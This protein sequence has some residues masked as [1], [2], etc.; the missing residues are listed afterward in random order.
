MAVARNL[1]VHRHHVENFFHR[2]K[3]LRQIATPYDKLA[4]VFLNFILLAAS[5][6]WIDSF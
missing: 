1:A 5:I 4:Q 3:R 2:I 6:D